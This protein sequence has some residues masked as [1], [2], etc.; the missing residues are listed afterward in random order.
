M[1]R[2]PYTKQFYTVNSKLI[3]NALVLRPPQQESL[4]CFAR[5]CDLLS[6]G[7]E[8]NLDEEL[9][10]IR[11]FYPTLT[12]FERNFPSFCFACSLLYQIFGCLSTLLTV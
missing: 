1:L 11:R 7:K 2:E 8:P 4:E 6:L 12:D 10:I 3:S 9:Q 5:I